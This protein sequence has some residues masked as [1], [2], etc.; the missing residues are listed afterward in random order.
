[1]P[2][3]AS[4]GGAV[5]YPVPLSSHT[6][7]VNDDEDAAE[8]CFI[9]TKHVQMPQRVTPATAQGLTCDCLTHNVLHQAC[10]DEWYNK[11]GTCPFCRSAGADTDAIRLHIRETVETVQ[12]EA[13]EIIRRKN[14]RLVVVGALTVCAMLCVFAFLLIHHNPAYS[15][16]DDWQHTHDDDHTTK[17]ASVHTQGTTPGVWHLSRE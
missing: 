5:V 8:E 10:F 9:C 7:D 6:T 16:D 17:A 1:M 4:S 13:E 12:Q 15:D 2:T 3:V 11:K 14:R